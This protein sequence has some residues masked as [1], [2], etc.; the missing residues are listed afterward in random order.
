MNWKEIKDGAPI[1]FGWYSVAVNPANWT[2][3]EDKTQLNDWRED[4][5]FTKAWYNGQKWFDSKMEE[6]SDRVTHWDNLPK[7]PLY[8]FQ[9]NE[10]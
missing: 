9:E 5:G 3:F 1:G 2:D 10:K 8:P 4:F 6:I 7:V